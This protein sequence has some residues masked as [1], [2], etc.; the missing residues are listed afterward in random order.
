MQLNKLPTSVH[1]PSKFRLVGSMM[2]SR[3]FR[4]TFSC[5]RGDAMYKE[6]ICDML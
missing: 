3:G 6:D 2:N 5:K 1:A 4:E